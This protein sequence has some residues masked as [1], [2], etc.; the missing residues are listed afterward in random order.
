MRVV[1]LSDTH[2][3]NEKIPVPEGD[4]LIHCGD[5]TNEGTIQEVGAFTSWFGNLPHKHKVFVAGNHDWLFQKQPGLAKQMCL[6][7]GITYLEDR[8]TTI[9]G[10]HIY[11][12]PWT[13]NF[14]EWAFMLDEEEDLYEKFQHIPSGLDILVTHGPPFGVLDEVRDNYKLRYCGSKALKDVVEKQKPRVHAFGHIHMGYGQKQTEHTHY[15]NAAVWWT[16]H[17]M[18]PKNAPICIDLEAR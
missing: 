11:G 6:D 13:P 5:A 14:M 16:L 18:T 10:L 12:T 1:F 4:L 2:G 15:I 7:Y 8:G 3:F 17:D 9:E